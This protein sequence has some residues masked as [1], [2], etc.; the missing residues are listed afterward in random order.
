MDEQV[1]YYIECFDTSAG[2]LPDLVLRRKGYDR[3]LWVAQR[4]AAAGFRVRMWRHG[5]EGNRL[6]GYVAPREDMLA[7]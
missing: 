4:L 7:R 6:L 5:D 3:A 2:A 1:T